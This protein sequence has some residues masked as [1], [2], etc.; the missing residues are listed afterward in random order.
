M[1]K[2]SNKLI[3]H[4]LREILE[5]GP[6]DDLSKFSDDIALTVIFSEYEDEIE[7]H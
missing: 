2:I 7:F 3:E 6:S 4:K 5:L 1:S